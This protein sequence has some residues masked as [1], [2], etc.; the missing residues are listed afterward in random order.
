MHA[1]VWMAS[2]HFRGP[3]AVQTQ[4]GWMDAEPFPAAET[5]LLHVCLAGSQVRA[6]GLRLSQKQPASCCSAVLD[7][8]NPWVIDKFRMHF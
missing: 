3:E 8:K 2:G 6:Q 4:L 7:C 1:C 5:L